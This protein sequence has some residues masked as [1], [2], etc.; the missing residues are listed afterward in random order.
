MFHRQSVQ[1]AA[2]RYNR[3]LF[4]KEAETV[5]ALEKTEQSG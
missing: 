4:H 3:A 5:N 2:R 1:A